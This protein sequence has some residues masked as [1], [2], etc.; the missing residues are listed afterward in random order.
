MKIWEGTELE[1]KNNNLTHN[2]DSGKLVANPGCT[3]E[4]NLINHH[5]HQHDKTLDSVDAA[6]KQCY[7]VLWTDLSQ[8]T[9]LIY[10]L[11]GRPVGGYSLADFAQAGVNNFFP[12]K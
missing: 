10:N 8:L 9:A 11:Q 3:V 5:Q 7:R 4:R 2:H 1:K 6:L 12:L